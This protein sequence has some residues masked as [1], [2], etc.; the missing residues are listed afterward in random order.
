MPKSLFWCYNIRILYILEASFSNSWTDYCFLILVFFNLFL[1]LPQS[2]FFLFLFYFI[3]T[4]WISELAAFF[5]LNLSLS[6][7]FLWLLFHF[8]FYIQVC[9]INTFIPKPDPKFI[10]NIVC[11]IYISCISNTKLIVMYLELC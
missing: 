2:F 4:I 9:L 1:Y 6:K 11:I 8:F 3:S 7:S 5:V 10:I